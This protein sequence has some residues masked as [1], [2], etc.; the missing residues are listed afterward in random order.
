MRVAFGFGNATAHVQPCGAQVTFR[1]GDSVI[2]CEAT[3]PSY[4]AEVDCGANEFPGSALEVQLRARV[5]PRAAGNPSQAD[6]NKLCSSPEGAVWTGWSSPYS[7]I[8]AAPAASEAASVAWIAG[9]SRQGNTDHTAGGLLRIPV[10]LP[11]LMQ[12]AE[13]AAIRAAKLQNWSAGAAGT[14]AATASAVLRVTTPAYAEVHLGMPPPLSPKEGAQHSGASTC[15]Q[16]MP[17]GRGSSKLGMQSALWS[18]SQFEISV[19]QKA[20]DV[21]SCVMSARSAMDGESFG[22]NTSSNATAVVGVA[23][24]RGYW[25]HFEYGE[26]RVAVSMSVGVNLVSNRGQF[27]GN[28]EAGQ[29]HGSLGDVRSAVATVSFDLGA[30]GLAGASPGSATVSLHPIDSDG[31]LV[32]NSDASH[33]P[34]QV[35]LPAPTL[36]WPAIVAGH[37]STDQDE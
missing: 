21:S 19:Y 37:T 28:S 6:L 2:R 16:A 7:V 4:W 15:Q 35:D 5:V 12:R 30:L 9:T 14:T 34:V 3:A 32:P 18:P 10:H 1:H 23:M 26:P 31:R 11:S 29:I 33:N 20:F 8:L 22:L 36:E 13:H 24:G 17:V 25:S 27:L